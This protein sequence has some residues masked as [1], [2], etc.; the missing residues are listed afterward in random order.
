[1][2]TTLADHLEGPNLIPWLV[3][4]GAALDTVEA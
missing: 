4:A 3:F 2:R 1:M